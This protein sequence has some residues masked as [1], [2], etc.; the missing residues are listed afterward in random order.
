MK[1]ILIL[2]FLA[3][4]VSCGGGNQSLPNGEYQNS[5]SDEFWSSFAI[6]TTNQK[7]A[8]NSSINKTL[9][10]DLSQSSLAPLLNT[11][12]NESDL[13]NL[14]CSNFNQLNETQKKL[15]YVVFLASIA[16]R[17]SD[18]DPR[19][20]TGTNIGLLQIDRTS[21]VRHAKEVVGSYVS[22]EDLMIA[23]T[24]LFVGAFILKNQVSGAFR[25]ESNGRLFPDRIYYWEV[26]NDKYRSRVIKS[27]LNNRSNLPFCME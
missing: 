20:V 3:L 23:E 12:L 6:K 11:N 1:T 19:N 17:E 2:S 24:N 8:W 10:D 14:K 16:E 21:A 9:F 15:F 25:G 7:E 27:F 22:V 13:A 26:L 5:L 18:F 4:L